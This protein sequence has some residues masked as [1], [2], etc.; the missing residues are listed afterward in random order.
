LRPDC[1]VCVFS[2][3]QSGHVSAFLSSGVP[4]RA[5]GDRGW[6]GLAGW[7]KAQI[8]GKTRNRGRDWAEYH[9]PDVKK[10]VTG[11]QV[12]GRLEMLLQ[13]GKASPTTHAK[14]RG[15]GQHAPQ[16]S[17][18]DCGTDHIISGRTRRGTYAFSLS[19]FFFFFAN[20]SLSLLCGLQCSAHVLV[21]TTSSISLF[22]SLE[23]ASPFHRQL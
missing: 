13:G 18:D 8:R 15:G 10:T 5:P 3:R 14:D 11:D 17:I 22:S 23:H 19:L 9:R 16:L 6:P 1:R 7:I 21:N 12:G 2:R 4:E 20:F